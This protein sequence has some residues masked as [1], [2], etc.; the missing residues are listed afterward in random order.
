MIKKKKTVTKKNT[1]AEGLIV[2]QSKFKHEYCEMLI[3]H[4]KTGKSYD[5]FPSLLYDRFKVSVGLS[6]MYEW[7]QTYKNW[8]KAKEMALSKALNFLETRVFAK[9]S[10]QKIDGINPKDIDSYLLMGM[11]KT[12][13]YKIYGDKQHVTQDVKSISINI[14]KDEF[15]I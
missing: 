9:I 11:L 4:M 7:E 14:S 8:G 2:K 3:D 10:G 6:T 15:E 12:R 5:S 13:F 1:K